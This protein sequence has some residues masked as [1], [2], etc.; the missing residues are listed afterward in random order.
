M[1]VL[2][3][4]PENHQAVCNWYDRLKEVKNHPKTT[5]ICQSPEEFRAQFDKDKFGAR[6][7]TFYFDEEFGMINTVKCFK[8]FVRLYGDEDARYISEAMKMRTIS[9][10]RLLLAGDFNVFKGFC[11]DPC[12]IDDVIRS[13]KRP[14]SCKS[15]L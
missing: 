7:T 15:L 11:I 2:F 12:C 6:Y 4:K 14:L 8:E 3:V 9:I 5:V 1:R 10:D 13:A